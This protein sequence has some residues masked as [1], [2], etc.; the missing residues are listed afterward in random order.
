MQ[1]GKDYR[2]EH[3]QVFPT[4]AGLLKETLEA[5]LE[6]KKHPQQIE[7]MVRGC[8]HIAELIE[9]QGNQWEEVK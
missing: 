1:P 4:P 6:A 8:I 3:R 2:I 7:T 5:M 9:K